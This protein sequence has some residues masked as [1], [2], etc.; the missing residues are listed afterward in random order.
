[1]TKE[2][3]VGRS[4][5]EVFEVIVSFKPTGVKVIFVNLQGHGGGGSEVSPKDAQT[6]QYKN[7]GHDGVTDYFVWPLQ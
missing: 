7:R 2:I 6:K 4:K 1:M 5:D 3:I